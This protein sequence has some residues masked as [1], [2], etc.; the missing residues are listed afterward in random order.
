[1]NIHVG[2]KIRLPSDCFFSIGMGTLS[3]VFKLPNSIEP[4]NFVKIGPQLRVILEMISIT[5]GNEDQ[6]F[7]TAEGNKVKQTLRICRILHSLLLEFSVQCTMISDSLKSGIKT[8]YS[9]RPAASSS[10]IMTVWHCRNY[11]II[12]IF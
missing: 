1:M 2:P 8:F 10:E 3:M 12:I 7:S 5:D 4:Q 9:I 11:V 6:S